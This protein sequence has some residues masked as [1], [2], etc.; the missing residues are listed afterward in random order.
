MVLHNP[1]AQTP[2]WLVENSRLWHKKNLRVTLHSLVEV[3]VFNGRKGKAF[4]ESVDLLEQI[5]PNSKIAGP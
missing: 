4:I 1:P 5:F 2:L 3:Y